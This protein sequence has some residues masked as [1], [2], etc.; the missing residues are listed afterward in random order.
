MR[1]LTRLGLLVAVTLGL[2]TLYSQAYKPW[3]E[4]WGATDSEVR[5]ALPGDEIVTDPAAAQETRAITIRAPADRVWPWVAQLGQDR[6][7]F[8]SYEILEDLVGCDMPHTD[9]I[10]PEMQKW[11]IDDRLWMYPPERAK[12]IGY[13]TLAAY[14]PG[15]VL[16]F[17]TQ[18]AGSWSFV[19]EPL[20]EKTTRLLIRG[21]GDP[22]LGTWFNWGVFTPM[23]FVMEK[24]MM[25]ELRDRAEGEP[26]SWAANNVQVA[27]WALTFALLI[28]S[29]V[30]VFTREHPGRA[31]FTFLAA[32]IVLQLLT[33]VQPSPL[34]G[35]I[36]VFLVAEMHIAA[37][38]E[39]RIALRAARRK[40][41]TA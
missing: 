24:R 6:A 34:I 22:G 1:A 16:G 29:A 14:E 33:L 12:G 25:L 17:R 32:G 27:L 7:G 41:A 30:T 2:F 3:F 13:A 35:W 40:L 26:V 19:L 5:R 38:R 15:R 37:T 21:R 20:D 11:A 28:A 39:R 23:H 18:P 8:Y 4:R 10:H 36:P 9:R 31:L